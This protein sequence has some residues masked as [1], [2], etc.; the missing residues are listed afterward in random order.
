MLKV[1]KTS[2]AAEKAQLSYNSAVAKYGE[3][4]AQAEAALNTY[5]I[6]QQ[7]L[8]IAK[9]KLDALKK[10][11]VTTVYTY[12]KAIQNEDGSLKSFSETI[13]FLRK[14]LNGLSDAEKTAAVSQISS[15]RSSGRISRF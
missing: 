2:N 1:Q 3:D 7:E 14:N 6:K 8:A 13:D 4:S 15:A 5:S 10:G 12:N 9:K 11:E